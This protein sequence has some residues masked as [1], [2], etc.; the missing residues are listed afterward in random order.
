MPVTGFSVESSNKADGLIVAH[1]AV[2]MGNGTT[3]GLG[4]V[5]G[6]QHRDSQGAERDVHGAAWHLAA[7]QLRSEHGGLRQR[8]ASSDPG[9]AAVRGDTTLLRLI[10]PIQAWLDNP[11]VTDIVVNKPHEVGVREA[12]KWHWMDVPSFDFDRL[13]AATILIGAAGR[14]GVRRGK[15]LRQQ[16]DARRPAV[17]GRQTPWNQG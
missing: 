17:P 9:P 5:S 6:R 1:Q 15:S 2:V 8:R 16:H 10:A 14:P 12:G 13:D 11:D 3:V 4:N 7:R